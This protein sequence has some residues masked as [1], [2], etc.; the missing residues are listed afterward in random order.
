MVLSQTN[1]VLRLQVQIIRRDGG[2]Q[3]RLA[4]KP[5]VV[6][7]YAELMAE[8]VKFPPV[9]TWFDG[10]EYW[11]SDGFQRLAAA[12]LI[13]VETVD[14]EVLHG[15][16]DDA[17][18]DSYAANRFH[19]L[20]RTRA[21]MEVIIERALVH[22]HSK[23][24]SNVQ[25]AQHLSVSEA[26]IRR[27]RTHLSSSGDEDRMRIARRG[28]SS[29][30][31][32]VCNIGKCNDGRTSRIKSRRALQQDLDTMKGLASPE[33]RRV[34]NIVGNWIFAGCSPE[35]CLEA[36]ETVVRDLRVLK[37]DRTHSLTRA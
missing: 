2:T 31:I 27:W 22:P 15:N 30:S 12:D 11:L 36:I 14:A 8:G 4:L 1:E 34:L 29:Y 16:I 37:A 5:T 25:I 3:G 23:Q 18:W 20:R 7:E 13:K 26:T 9:R 28:D 6:K 17:R 21:D 24:L 33:A 19:G 35:S 10:C 32:N